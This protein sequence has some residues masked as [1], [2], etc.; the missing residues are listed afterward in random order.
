VKW[1]TFVLLYDKFIQDTT[2]HNLSESSKFYRRYDKNILAYFFWDTV[3][4]RLIAAVMTR[5]GAVFIRLQHCSKWSWDF[6]S[7]NA[8]NE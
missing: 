6:T 2:Y 1:E 7:N 3:Y 4:I 5:H 8:C